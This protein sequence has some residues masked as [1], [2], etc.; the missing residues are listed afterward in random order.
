M[1]NNNIV[2]C[3]CETNCLS[4]HQQSFPSGSFISVLFPKQ[5]PKVIKIALRS[6]W[7]ARYS[8]V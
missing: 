3:S 5:F 2:T 1:F 4:V 7:Y 8:R 6:Y